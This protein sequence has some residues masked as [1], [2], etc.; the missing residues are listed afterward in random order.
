MS[1]SALREWITSGRPVSRAAVADGDHLGMPR[2]RDEI[3]C[4]DVELFVGVMRVRADRAEHV[5]ETLSDRQQSVLPPHAGR[6][7]D[8]PPDA[9]VARAAYD[10]VEVVGEVRKVEMAVAVDQHGGHAFAASGST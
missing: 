1:A 2:A 8:D 3:G 6:D 9:G 7:R 5:R 4:R 10:A